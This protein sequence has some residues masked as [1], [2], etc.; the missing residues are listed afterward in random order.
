M[1]RAFVTGASGFIASNLVDQLLANGIEVVAYDNLSTGQRE[2]LEPAAL[3]PLFRF[4]QGDILNVE[5]LTPSMRGA[6]IVFHFAA[7]ADLRFGPDHPDRD[8][9]QNTIGTFNV[10]EAMRKNGISRIA[11]SS[12]SA[13]YGEPAVVPTP[14]DCPFP[15]QTSLYG[16]SKLAGEGLI[17]AYCEAFQFEGTI[18]RF[19][20][21]L[22]KRYTHGHVF[23]FYKQ[24][25]AHPSSLKVLGNGRQK[26]S[27]MDITDCVA[28]ILVAVN[29]GA[30][31]R[32]KHRAE[33]FNLGTPAYCEVLD[34]IRWISEAM[35]AKPEITFTGGDRGWVGDNPF[36]FLS[37]EKIMKLGWKPRFDI[38][39][40]V[41]RTVQWLSENHWVLERR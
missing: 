6:D 15:I 19:A 28:A 12:T 39:T 7:N 20:S 29:S 33:V 10:L 21:V 5:L 18:F 37:V 35:G 24:L 16:T 23:D 36:L 3:S 31:S 30:A 9:Q 11:F 1:K 17:T 25:L 41:K 2:F 26:K 8:L 14:E 40:S 38:E 22:G 27:Y 32:A 34:S 13:V 4:I